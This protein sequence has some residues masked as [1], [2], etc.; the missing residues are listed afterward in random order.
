VGLFFVIM[1]ALILHEEKGGVA[2]MAVFG[3]LL[4][5]SGQPFFGRPRTGGPAE[6]RFPANPWLD[7]CGGL[8]V[9]AG[10]VL[11]LHLVENWRGRR[12]WQRVKAELEAKGE[13]LDFDTFLKPPVPDD[14]NVMAHPY[15]K[16]HFLKGM[17]T[18]PI[19]YPP[20]F[21]N[22][23]GQPYALSGLKKLRRQAEAGE[24][25]LTLVGDRGSREVI[26]LLQFTNQPLASVFADLARQAGLKFTDA[27]NQVPWIELR[28]RAKDLTHHRVTFS[29]TNSTALQAMDKIAQARFL[30]V[31][32]R[33]W[34]ES[35]VLAMAED[36]QPSLQGLLDWY[37]QYRAEFAQLEEALQRPH[38]HLAHD[39][40]HPDASPLPHF[41]SLRLVAQSYANLCKL[42][43]L[44][45]DADAALKDLRMLRRSMDIS[46]SLEPPTLVEAMI[47]VAIAGLLASTV[48]E[49]LT[50][51]LWPNSHLE[52][53]QQAC[54]GV[55]LLGA[56]S[57]AFR[58]GERAGVLR[59]IET[60]AKEDKGRL[61]ARITGGWTETPSRTRALFLG[62][63]VPNG[64]V[65]QSKAH[66]AR[67]MQ[68]LVVGLHPETQR[69][70][71]RALDAGYGHIASELEGGNHF[72]PYSLL[73]SAASP[74]FSKGGPTATKNITLVNLAYVALALECHRA[75][76]SAYPDALVALVP[77][78]APALPHDLFDGQP[79]R[80]RRTPDGKYL[81]YSIGWNS[82]DDGGTA[83]VDKAGKPQPFGS[84]PDWVWQGVPIK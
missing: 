4:A 66:Y 78:F 24:S 65:D 80:Y 21:F 84:G 14:Q 53:V 1:A 15:M 27:T 29:L 35:G 11:T 68:H 9:F 45:G 64:W 71:V 2:V 75:A 8:A 52:G 67:T 3:F 79:L 13:S 30:T 20:V 6:Q 51:G 33:Q 44:M 23:G 36:K 41:V 38:A 40:L 61:I 55:D 60:G 49:T 70:D 73:S 34:R 16:K 69:V 22:L 47:R 54:D 59:M 72:R 56:V 48:E 25:L 26:P 17:K 18:M 74:N 62:L 57:L 28:R 82:K 76:K 32:V 10:L 39:R 63:S 37:G 5:V 81:L 7:A 58:G 83:G 46:Q 43:L 12:E 50:D 42:H 19:N 77:E 31:D